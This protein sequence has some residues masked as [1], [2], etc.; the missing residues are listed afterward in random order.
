MTM[1]ALE[2]RRTLALA[3]L[4]I[5]TNGTSGR[6]EGDPIYIAV[7]E[8]RDTGKA[9]S[10]CGDLAHWLLYRLGLRCDWLN[11]AEGLN[12][13]AGRNISKLAFSCPVARGPKDGE[14]YSPGDVLLVWNRPDGTDAHAIVVSHHCS[15]NLETAEYGQP[16]GARRNHTIVSGR[17]G[18]RRIQRVIPL[19]DAL[20]SAEASAQL[21]EPQ[22]IESWLKLTDVRPEMLPRLQRGTRSAYVL[23][24]QSFLRVMIDGE[25]GANTIRAVQRLQ[26]NSGLPATGII[27]LATWSAL[28]RKAP[29]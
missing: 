11:R 16:G 8:A 17:I 9:Y 25:Y 27:D 23:L 13:R 10:S 5:A 18:A 29:Q 1:L 12:Y 19:E 4:D 24:A 14:L 21:V 15:T 7:T 26:T 2:A 3:Y 28:L 6:H 22:S 20:Q